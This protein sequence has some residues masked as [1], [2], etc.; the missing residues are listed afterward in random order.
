MFLSNINLNKILPESY[1]R[2]DERILEYLSKQSLEEVQESIDK[3]MKDK[4]VKKKA[5]KKQIL[6]KI[7]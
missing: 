2:G 4:T 5:D 6:S 3:I 7:N 1:Y